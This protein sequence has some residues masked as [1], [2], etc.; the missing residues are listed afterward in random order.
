MFRYFNSNF[1]GTGRRLRQAIVVCAAL[2]IAACSGLRVEEDIPREVPGG[3]STYTSNKMPTGND[4]G[5][6]FG[7]GGFSL[8]GNRGASNGGAGLGVNALLWQATLETISF[9]PLVQADPFGG[10]ILTDWYSAEGAPS[11]RLKLSV[12][13]LGT[14]LR[15]DSVRVSMFRQ[16]R[17]GGDTWED[18]AVQPASAVGVENA[19]LTRARLLRRERASAR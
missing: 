7:E 8:G 3:Q 19:I 11:E 14:D 4:I 16:R 5:S 18:V 2:A 17:A 10:V 12:F 9:M 13:I 15:A 6:I 1:E